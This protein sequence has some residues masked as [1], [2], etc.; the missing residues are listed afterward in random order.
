MLTKIRNE[1]EYKAAMRTVESLLT[2]ATEAGGFHKLQAEEATMLANLSKLAQAYE[3]N[4]LKLMPIVPKTLKEAVS[5]L[6]LNRL[7]LDES[8]LTLNC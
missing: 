4:V 5:F 1:R 7:R 3:D 2:K 6:K 8:L